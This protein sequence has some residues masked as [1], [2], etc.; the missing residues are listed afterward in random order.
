MTG[1]AR[2]K[3]SKG[4]V[5]DRRKKLS[6]SIVAKWASSGP[7]VPK[8]IWFNRYKG[9]TFIRNVLLA[10]KRY[11]RDRY[12]VGE[13]V[14]GGLVSN[15]RRQLEDVIVTENLNCSL[16]CECD[17]CLGDDRA[18]LDRC[19]RCGEGGWCESGCYVDFCS[20]DCC[21]EGQ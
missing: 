12:G 3:Q 21:C 14:V 5:K 8:Y 9:R 15:V 2:A 16:M 17:S 20:C 18:K 10:M 19:A 13:Q 4:G 11:V 1:R 7:G 6:D